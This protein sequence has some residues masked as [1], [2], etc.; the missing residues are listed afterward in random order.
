M[1]DQ[2]AWPSLLSWLQLK[3]QSPPDTPAESGKPPLNVAWE[4]WFQR[5]SIGP[6]GKTR[7]EQR[8]QQLCILVWEAKNETHQEPPPPLRIVFLASFFIFTSALTMRFPGT[9]RLSQS[10]QKS[11]LFIAWILN[12]FSSC[13]SKS[14]WYLR[15]K[16]TGPPWLWVKNRATSK[17]NPGKWKHGVKPAVPWWFHFDPYPYP[18]RFSEP[19]QRLEEPFL[20]TGCLG[21]QGM[22]RRVASLFFQFW[23]FCGMG[24]AVCYDFFTNQ[25]PHFLDLSGGF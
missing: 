14:A 15:R 6:I 8:K 13:A 3:D 19:F 21:K 2:F 23:N 10:R 20:G 11:L 7:R 4:V 17:W 9:S 1:S 5:P 25:E 12:H 18:G 22:S 16:H 24:S